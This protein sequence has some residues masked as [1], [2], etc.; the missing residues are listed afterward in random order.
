MHIFESKLSF[1]ENWNLFNFHKLIQRNNDIIHEEYK[2][3]D[4]LSYIFQIFHISWI[5]WELFDN[6][7]W[8]IIQIQ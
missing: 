4:L 8:N 2:Y 6:M 7:Q 3:Y 1:N 5:N